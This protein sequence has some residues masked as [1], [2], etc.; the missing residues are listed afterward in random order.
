MNPLLHSALL[1]GGIGLVVVLSYLDTRNKE[2]RMKAFLDAYAEPLGEIAFEQK[3][4][5][6]GW[7]Q[8]KHGMYVIPHGLYVVYPDW[9]SSQ[10]LV[11]AQEGAKLT[12]PPRAGRMKI[13]ALEKERDALYLKAVG[14]GGGHWLKLAT[15]TPEQREKILA[16][17]ECSRELPPA[18]AVD[19]KEG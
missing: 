18:L 1:L 9:K 19:A 5:I 14:D 7:R 15:L 16:Q 10:P 11:Y 2:R 12:L 8:M 17:L 4:V 6:T 3:G 13:L